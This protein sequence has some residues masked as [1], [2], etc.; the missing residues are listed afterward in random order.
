MSIPVAQSVEHGVILILG[1]GSMNNKL[2]SSIL[3]LVLVL[4]F[5]T[6]HCLY[7]FTFQ[8]TR[9]GFLKVFFV[10]YSHFMIAQ[11]Y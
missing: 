1:I 3:Q 7:Q 8:T 10:V 4:R 2:L 11:T 5:G 6:F 9:A